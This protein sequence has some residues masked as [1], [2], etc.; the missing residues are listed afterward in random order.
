M[1][2]R[3]VAE[4]L[5]EHLVLKFNQVPEPL[6]ETQVA[7]SMARSVMTGVSL[8][9]FEAVADE[10]RSALEIAN[11]CSTHPGAT[12][13]LLNAL[14]SCGYFTFRRDRYALRPKARKWLLRRSPKNLCDKLLFQFYEWDLVT[15]YETFV[16]T[17]TP[18]RTHS[19]I[20]DNGYWDVYQKGMRNLAALWADDVAARFPTLPQ[21]Q[22][23]LDIGGSHGYFS[24]CLCRKFTG[25]KSVILDLPEAIKYAAPLLAQENM[26]ERITHRV[27]DALTADLGDRS[28]DIVFMSQLVHHFTDMQNRELMKRI[29]RALRPE[30]VCVILDSVSAQA[31]GG[32]DQT[33]ALFDLY[34]AML[35]DC[36]KNAKLRATSFRAS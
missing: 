24:V 27:G 32:G 11:A 30:G 34:F 4:N 14:T 36:K 3:T 28:V 13:K 6:V 18:H 23:M 20:V 10:P 33:A 1:R 25:L 17:G 8:G 29:A 15:G 2:L 21:A 7:F 12:E 22:D 16:R 5:V 19:S 9:L 31:P 26:G 35:S